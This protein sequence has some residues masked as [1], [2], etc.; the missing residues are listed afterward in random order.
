VQN[1]LRGQ[2]FIVNDNVVYQDNQSAILLER[3]GCGSSGRRTRH[4]NIRYY[5]ITD[6]IK[7][8]QLQVAYCPTSDMIADFFTKPL[9]GALFKKM[10]AKIMNLDESLALPLT[11][12]GPQ[13]CVESPSWASIVK[14]GLVRTL[15]ESK[16]TSSTCDHR[17]SESCKDTQKDLQQQQ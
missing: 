3:N 7:R 11:T 6:C 1:F 10:R 15:S 9:Q 8:K 17:F 16:D 12:A 5:F 2:G 13:E 14:M 4:I